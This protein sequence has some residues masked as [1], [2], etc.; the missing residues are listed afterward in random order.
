MVR[1][2]K[3]A[4]RAKYSE[5]LTKLIE[6]YSQILIVDTNN[7]GS[8]LMQ[9]IRKDLRGWAEMLFGKN[10]LIRKVVEENPNLRELMPHIKEKFVLLFTKE[11][12]TVIESILGLHNLKAPARSG[13]IAPTD[14]IIKIQTTALAPEKTSFF[15]AVKIPTQIKKGTI[16]IKEDIHLVKAGDIISQSQ[17]TMLQLL[18]I[19]PFKLELTIKKIFKGGTISDAPALRKIKE[20]LMDGIQR[21]AAVKKALTGE[22]SANNEKED[23]EISDTD[24]EDDMGLGLFD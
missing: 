13:R 1:E 2:E 6:D 8:N 24:D 16:H 20:V 17:A 15:Q 14:V 18:G 21:C 9:T 7:V 11:D 3:I 23:D 12:Y 5:K 22:D 19:K 4:R 10:T